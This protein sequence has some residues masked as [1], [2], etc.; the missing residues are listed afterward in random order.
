MIIIVI[1][2]YNIVTCIS[3]TIDDV[4][5]VIGFIEHLYTICNYK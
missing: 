2:I 3:V 4:W 5:I 1:I